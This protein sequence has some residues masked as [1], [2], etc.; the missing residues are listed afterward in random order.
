MKWFIGPKPDGGQYGGAHFVTKDEPQFSR[1]YTVANGVL[2][3]RAYYDG[4]YKDPE[5]WGRQWYSGQISS[6]FPDDRVTGAVRTG[7]F[8]MRAKL[9]AVRGAWPAF[10]LGNV[11]GNRN[12]NGGLEVD[13]LEGY[14]RF[15]LGYVGTIHDWPGQSGKD[16]LFQQKHF[17][18][19]LGGANTQTDFHT[20]GLRITDTESIWYFDEKE[21]VRFPLYRAND[22]NLGAFFAMI[23]LSVGGG[24]PVDQ[25]K[26]GYMEML[27]DYVRIYSAD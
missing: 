1:I 13:I 27:V 23:D 9:P 22:T 18:N 7:Y 24:W 25:P 21:L 19:M 6:C 10:W 4:A 12:P 14:G 16:H 11:A 15:P 3:I 8:V 17:D 20:Y 2:S 26:S 5:G